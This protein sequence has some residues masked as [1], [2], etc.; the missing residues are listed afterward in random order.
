MNLIFYQKVDPND[1]ASNGAVRR[2][3]NYANK[4]GLRLFE[5]RGD[6]VFET[7]LQE[8]NVD[9]ECEGAVVLA[10]HERLSVDGLERMLDGCSYLAS[11]VSGR[12]TLDKRGFYFFRKDEEGLAKLETFADS[13]KSDVPNVKGQE[14][15]PESK[16]PKKT[17]TTKSKKKQKT[18]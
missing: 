18:E 13:K 9:D 14:E 5:H 16:E 4:R 12:R 15:P 6:G 10:E 1:P 3:R 17:K 11:V 8:M 2:N 7:V